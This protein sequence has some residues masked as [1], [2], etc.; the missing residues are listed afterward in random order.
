MKRSLQIVVSGEPVATI[1]EP[2]TNK[3][4]LT[5]D[6]EA[7]G[8]SALSVRL[9]I[10]PDRYA[11][12]DVNPYLAGLMPSLER[13][14]SLAEEHEVPAHLI[15]RFLEI[16]GS[17][18]PG[19]AQF[20]NTENPLPPVPDYSL[21]RPLSPADLVEEVAVVEHNGQWSIPANGEPS[22]HWLRPEDE[23]LPHSAAAE[24]LALRM[25]DAAGIDVCRSALTTVLGRP[26]VVVARPD[27]IATDEGGGTVGVVRRHL[28]DFGQACAID[29]FTSEEAIYQEWDGPGFLEMAEAIRTYAAEPRA[30]LQKLA[31]VMVLNAVVG[32]TNAHGA[33]FTILLP[34]RTLGPIHTLLPAEFYTELDTE[35]G[36]V[37]LD[38]RLA[39]SVNEFWKTDALDHGDFVAEASTW[40]GL[41]REGAIEAVNEILDRLPNALQIAAAST[42]EAPEGLVT[43]IA[44]RIDRFEA[45]RLASS[46]Q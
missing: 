9:P 16:L 20:L 17:D 43:M 28:E 12:A 15:F 44:E 3:F 37:E 14:E 22:S 25:A 26:A 40:P 38:H 7:S 13:R 41:S 39:M 45:P 33:S 34:E 1:A 23:M 5:Y 29:T 42:P 35:D 6:P 36:V 27:R 21:R 31:Q 30:Q 32:N 8:D 46:S 4:T 11:P 24:A 2:R 18:L 19:G 10:S